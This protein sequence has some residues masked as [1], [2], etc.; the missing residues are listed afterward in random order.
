MSIRNCLL[1]KTILLLILALDGLTFADASSEFID[2]LVLAG[3]EQIHREN[4][5]E[6][7]T[8]FKELIKLKPDKPVGYF[9][10]AGAYRTIMYDYRSLS[11]QKEFEHYVEKAI[12]LSKELIDSGQAT[13]EDYFYY[14]GALGYLGIFKSDI[15]S[16]WSAFRLGLRAKGVMEKALEMDST[17]YDAYFGLG[18][19]HY[20][21]SVK[22][23]IFWWLPFV[24]DDRAKG[25]SEIKFAIEN[26]KYTGREGKYALLRVYN[27]EEAYDTLLYYFESS[28]LRAYNPDDPYSLWWVGLAYIGKGEW[29]KATDNYRRL[30]RVLDN[31]PYSD[32]VGEVE[33]RYYLAHCYYNTNDYD[34]CL[35][36]IARVLSVKEKLK[37]RKPTKEFIDRAEELKKTIREELKRQR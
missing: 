37:D 24:G 22:T 23:R 12:D 29:S 35:A 18:T 34:S 27:E 1:A 3:I 33:C 13:S 16:W 2:S 9:F 15:G 26:G 20:W 17:N 36:E 5:E 19:Y 4:L 10:I 6:A 21:R 11:Y 14:A 8:T 31:S 7:I 32:G 25:I 30:L 28:G